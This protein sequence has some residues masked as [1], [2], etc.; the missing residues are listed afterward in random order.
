[1]A[2]PAIGAWVS[3]VGISSCESYDGKLVNVL[4]VSDEQGIGIISAP[5][6]STGMDIGAPPVLRS[7][8][9]RP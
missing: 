8:R 5:L 3:V 1:V 6:A 2:I 7:P 4:L 9:D